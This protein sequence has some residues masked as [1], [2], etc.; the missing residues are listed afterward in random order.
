MVGGGKVIEIHQMKA[1]GMS[2]REIARQTGHGRNTIRRY[3]CSG[4]PPRPK[5]RPPR[6]SKL[7]PFKEHV[8]A[9]MARGDSYRLR[10]K[11]QAGLLP[12]PMAH[13]QEALHPR[14]G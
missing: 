10:E 3:L 12:S 14:G 13:E 7:D 8:T 4:E 9:Q 2:I 6:G 1:S 11:R 5:P